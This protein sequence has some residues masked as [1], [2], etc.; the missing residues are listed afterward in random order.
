MSDTNPSLTKDKYNSV[1][2]I[3]DDK[4]YNR[5]VKKGETSNISTRFLQINGT[6]F[7]KEAFACTR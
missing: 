4:T 3:C 1:D 7:R 5:S 6:S 2:L